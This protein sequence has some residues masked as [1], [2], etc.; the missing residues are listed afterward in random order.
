MPSQPTL[1]LTNDDGIDAPGLSA[2]E[3]VVRT[4]FPNHRVVTVAPDRGRSECGHGVTQSRPLRVVQLDEDRY[5]IDGL[6]ADCVRVALLSICP[7]ATLVCSGINAGANLGMDV[8]VSGTVA[9]AR[10]AAIRGRDAVAIS[11]YRHPDIPRTWD[12]VDRWLGPV[13]PRLELNAFPGAG[14]S[15]NQSSAAPNRP[16]SGANPSTDAALAISKRDGTSAPRW[17]RF[18]NVNLPAI[19]PEGP[20]P[21]MV[22]CSVDPTPINPE[23]SIDDGLYTTE[24]DFHGR[25]RL[26]E[27]DVAECF[28]GAITI[29]HLFP[30]IAAG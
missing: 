25:S 17:G 5:S 15:S 11:H 23:P 12:H 19:D 21:R 9:A 6:P 3:S 27:H 22:H 30:G 28:G 18:I 29:S 10:E 26:P 13:W 4:Q 20:T 1:L 7:E 16:P 8:L 24:M 2:L 14:H